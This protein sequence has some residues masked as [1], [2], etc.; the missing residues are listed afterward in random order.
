MEYNLSGVGNR[1]FGQVGIG[2]TEDA[3]NLP[4]IVSFYGD[5]KLIKTVKVSLGNPSKVSL[6]VKGVLRLRI[7]ASLVQSV[8]DGRDIRVS[9]GDARYTS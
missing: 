4:A 7:S 3:S 5:S 6:S 2:D 1:F 9:V 8:Y